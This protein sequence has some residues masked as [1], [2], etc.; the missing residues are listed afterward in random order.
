MVVRIAGAFF[1]FRPRRTSVMLAAKSWHAFTV[2]VSLAGV[3][4]TASVHSVCFSA[5]MGCRVKV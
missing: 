4:F 5:A 2:R 3:F 1:F